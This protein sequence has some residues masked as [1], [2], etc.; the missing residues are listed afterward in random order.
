[1]LPMLRIGKVRNETQKKLL[2]KEGHKVIRKGKSK[3][4]T[5]ADFEKS[6]IDIN[7]IRI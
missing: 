3:N 7:I 4:F 2:E 6:L 1:M 5:V